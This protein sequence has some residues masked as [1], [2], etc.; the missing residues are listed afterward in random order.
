MARIS[1]RGGWLVAALMTSGFVFGAGCKEEKKTPAAGSGSAAVTTAAGSGSAAPA[2]APAGSGSAVAEQPAAPVAPAAP[3]AT[4]DHLG[5]LPKDSEI[6][7]GVNFQQVQKSDLWKQFVEPKLMK[8]NDFLADLQ[9]FKDKCG[10]DPMATIVS[11]SAGL[12][13]LDAKKPDGV[14]VVNGLDKA[15]TTACVEK[16]KEEFGK[17]GNE[18]TIDGDVMLMKNK[19]GETAAMHFVNDKT[20]LFV[21]GAAATKQGVMDAA[22]GTSALK[23]SPAFVEMYSKINTSESMWG[24]ANCGSKIFDEMR[25]QGINCKAV[26]GSLN[27]TD[28]VTTDIRIR[29]MSPDQATQLATMAK[30]QTGPAA[31]FVDKIDITTDG[32]DMKTSIV[33]SKAKLMTIIAMAGGRKGGGGAP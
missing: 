3:P 19:D 8:S 23:T 25:K 6:V 14:V 9:K 24:L 33:I 16:N 1:I 13:G 21:L 4:G 11:V 20:L 2:P 15:K 17:K 30:S 32:P 29:A 27:V 10:F 22:A 26:F 31:Q 5:L 7:M 18:L 12:K 28:G